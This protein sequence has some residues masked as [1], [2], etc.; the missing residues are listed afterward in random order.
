MIH[1]SYDFELLTE[2]C[3]KGWLVVGAGLEV[4]NALVGDFHYL[5][6]PG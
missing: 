3:A 2:V 4:E 6:L 1:L 5:I